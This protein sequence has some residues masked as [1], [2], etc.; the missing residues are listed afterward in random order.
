MFDKRHAPRIKTTM[1]IAFS[2]AGDF[3]CGHI[4]DIS[5]SGV[6]LHTETVLPVDTELALRIRLPYDLVSMDITGRV[7]W[8]KQSTNASPSGMGVEFLKMAWEDRK[9]IERFVEERI[10]KLNQSRNVKDSAE[11]V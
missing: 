9:R 5:C 3:L 11:A 8:T 6:F 2:S 7:A 4:M 10:R 1:A